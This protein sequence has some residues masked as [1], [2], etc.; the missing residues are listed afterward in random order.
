MNISKINPRRVVIIHWKNKIELQVEV[1]SNLKIMCIHYPEFNYNTLNNYL[2]KRKSPFENEKVKIERKEVNSV[3]KRGRKMAMVATR[4]K[5]EN[6]NE[7]LADLTYWLSR[8]AKERL[9]AVTA[10]RA[11]FMNPGERMDKSHISKRKM[12]S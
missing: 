7:E 1:F 2:S 6:H 9:E 11:Q 3:Q 5:Q 4:V 10:L 12:K 8:P